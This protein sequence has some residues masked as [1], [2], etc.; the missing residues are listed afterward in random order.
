MDYD[1][2]EK[3]KISELRRLSQSMDLYP[4]RKDTNGYIEV[5]KKAFKEYEQYKH[6]KIDRYIRIKQLGNKGKE[7]TVYL[8]EDTYTG[9]RY[10][11]KCFRKNKSSKNLLREVALQDRAS[12]MGVC[13][14]IID[15]DTI[16]KYIVME[17]LDH[18]LYDMLKK[19]NGLLSQNYQKQMISIFTKLDKIGI[20]HNDA[21]P[22]NFM[23]HNKK[24]YIIDFGYAKEINID[25]I[26]KHD[27]KRPNLKFMPLGFILKMH[28]IVPTVT[29]DILQKYVP[30]MN[31]ADTVK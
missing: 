23:I 22:L 25:L 19:R 21:S 13:P 15:Y 12:T 28:S 24:L 26:R 5:I 8:V 20:F 14:K 29:Y 1:K 31:I 30:S 6:N 7:G 2:L 17:Y 16:S 18:N 4:T 10:A 11:M 9:N 27:T 3:F